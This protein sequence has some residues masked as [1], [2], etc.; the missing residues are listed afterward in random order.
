MILFPYQQTGVKRMLNEDRSFLCDDMGLGKTAQAINTVMRGDR[1]PL[2]VVCPASLKWNWCNEIKRWM[3]IDIVPDVKSH[4]ILVTNY[5]RMNRIKG[6]LWKQVIFDESH[7]LKNPQS[8]RTKLAISTRAGYK[9]LITGTPMPDRP[10]DLVGQLTILQKIRD[11]RDEYNFLNRYCGVLHTNFGTS[12]SGASNM[13]ELKMKMN[14]IWIRRLKKDVLSQ[15][16][17]IKTVYTII[18]N[19]HDYPKSAKI[20]NLT[21]QQMAL[22]KAKEK[23]SAE[24]IENFLTTGKSLVV[25]AHHRSLVGYLKRQFPHASVIMGGMSSSQKQAMV[26]NFQSG[27][28]NLII[29]SL[30]CAEVG[31]TL[32]KA[33]DCAFLEYSWEDGNFEQALAR[34]HRI[35]Q[36]EDCTAYCLYFQDSVDEYIM[37]ASARKGINCD[38][39][40]NKIGG[41]A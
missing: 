27:K 10:R 13:S 1:F 18:G 41:L 7:Y 36:T 11:S 33:H 4:R 9:T 12:Y 8:A 39:L 22:A 19:M 17:K 26:D 23:P 24:W 14:R 16:P 31:L 15:L 40:T 38:Y 5:E 2:L 32:T 29:C 35:G 25:F 30:L 37:E 28:T 3:G 34:I 21:R 6:Y 20:Q